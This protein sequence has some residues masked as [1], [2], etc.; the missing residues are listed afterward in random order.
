MALA[1]CN[2]RFFAE[3]TLQ[4]KVVLTVHLPMKKFDVPHLSIAR[5]ALLVL[6]VTSVSAFAQTTIWTDATGDWF[7]A[8]NWSAGVPDSSTTAQINN[9]GTAQIMA[10]GAA[11]NLVELGIA[12]GDVGT[13]SVSG[14]G[15]LQGGGAIDIGEN[16]S[17]TLNITKGGTV[18][19]SDATVGTGSG[20]TGTALVDGPGSTWSHDGAITIGENAKATGTLTISNGGTMSTGGTGA[21]SIIGHNPTSS[22]TVN[23]T[24]AGS[25]WINSAALTLSDA[26]GVGILN[27]VDGGVVSSG[28]SILGTF[29]GG[30]TV[31][32]NGTGSTWTITGDLSV[33]DVFGGHG[34][35]SISQGSQ[36]SSTNGFIGDGS[37]SNGTVEVAGANATWN[38]SGNVYVGGNSTGAVGTGDLHL[39]NNGNVGAAAVTVWSTGR[40]TGKGFVQAALVTNHGTLT[41]DSI[42]S[43]TGD[44]TF[45]SAAIMSATVMP[46]A[47]GSVIVGG[48]AGL[49][50]NLNVTLTGG[51]FI[52]GM[53]YTL[54]LATGGLNG[55]TFANISI[56]APAGVTAQVTY[57]TNDVLLTIESSG[58]PTPT[59]TASPTV[60]PTVSPTATPTPTATT[61]PSATPRQTPTPRFVP[62]P[63]PRPTPPPR[64]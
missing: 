49:D 10:S 5:W 27:I 30:G 54:L 56:T 23:V 53:Q 32:L 7:T 40:L 64:P 62:T 3:T 37:G 42:I 41:P 39:F 28:D 9:G 44:L 19:D 1:P 22:G 57:D 60:T 15:T 61:T 14:T 18:S 13:L 47:A 11:A 63:R 34:T 8:A 50:G 51:P 17:G 20:S 33:G 29:S 46:D 48:T 16:G 38:N 59:P 31:T 43:I 52:V 26:G 6:L 58:T 35:V 45:D 25:T 36:I 21:G 12:T 55:T 4:G 24:G 2:R